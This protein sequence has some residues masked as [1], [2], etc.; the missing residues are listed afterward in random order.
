MVLKGRTGETS[1]VPCPL[2]WILILFMK[3]ILMKKTVGIIG[4][5]GPMA[6]ADL[7]EKITE[8]T[9]A[10]TDQEHLHVIIDSNT[11]IP[12]R[13]MA[14]LSGGPDPLEEMTRSLKRLISAGADILAM[15]CNTAHCYYDKLCCFTTLPIVNMIEET[16]TYIQN[17]G[18]S[19]VALLGTDGLLEIGPY[20]KALGQKRIHFRLLS[21]TG[22]KEL[23]KL[24][25][26]GVKAG[27]TC[28]EISE[29][30][31][32]LAAM[33][34]DGVQAFVLACT[35]LPIAFK[36]Y[37]IKGLTVDPTLILARAIIR[38]AGA[39]LA[40]AESTLK[41]AANL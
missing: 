40:S 5:M 13:T 6:T 27:N 23:M 16:V 20:Q 9:L 19:E 29:L 3:E 25:Y 18:L 26:R 21:A 10:K 24:I 11:N 7:F 31:R 12:D 15:P 37:H 30:Q 34:Q 38:K 36:Q 28:L 17:Q 1:F 4:G 8:N 22:Q 35:E 2:R 14:L 33:E 32:E 41:R 39:S